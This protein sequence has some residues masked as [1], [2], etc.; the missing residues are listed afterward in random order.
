MKK[1]KGTMI[2]CILDGWGVSSACTHNAICK[3][4]TPTWDRMV[5]EYPYTEIHASALHVGLPEGQMGN[6]E[7][8]HVNIGA[9]RVVL[10]SLPRVNKVVA[11]NSF[12]QI[13]GFNQLV[14]HCNDT[15]ATV[16]LMGLLS[17]GGVHSDILHTIAIAKALTEAGV[18]VSLHA[19][20][21][22]R[23]TE[24]KTAHKYVKQY[25]DAMGDKAPVMSVSGRYFSMDRDNRWDRVEK[26]YKSLFGKAPESF[27]D[28]I[29]YIEDAYP[30]IDSEEFVEPA[31]HADF[32]GIQDNDC[33]L[34]FN[35][36]ADRAREMT[37]ALIG[38]DF[39]HFPL[40][41]VKTAFITTLTEYSEDLTKDTLIMFDAEAVNNTI[42]QI[43]ADKGLTQLRI[44]ETEKYAHVTFFMNGGNEAVYPNEDRILIPSPNVATYDMQPEMSAP[45]VTKNIVESLRS[46]KHDLIIVNYANGDMVGHTGDLD[47]AIKAAECVDQQLAELEA[48]IKETDSC[49]IISADHGNAELMFNEDTGKSHTAHTSNPVPVVVVN[50]PEPIT[51]KTGD[52]LNLA[53]LSPTVLK[54]MDIELPAEMDAGDLLAS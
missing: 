18:N 45:E 52:E 34:F 22:G 6:S 23:D 13:E 8:G 27:T 47:A 43:I 29:K 9:G 28:P 26:G 25:Q 38:K 48:V 46:N 16:H 50:Y 7:V 19:F 37:Q 40:E 35:F 54:F 17:D 24:P 44:A 49:M 10:Q 11:E 41:P 5:K 2:L 36:R 53:N 4:N 30:G 33:V 32:K 14:R 20:L 39:D 51:L 1:F 42:G 12:D 21:D 15:G 3:G 31:Q